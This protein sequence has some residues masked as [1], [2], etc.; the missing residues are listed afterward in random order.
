M[1][2]GI[3]A[4]FYGSIGKGL[5][6]Y[7]EKLIEYLETLDTENEYVIFL[8]KENFDEYVP[9]NRHFEKRLA[10]YS[11]Y[12]FLEQILF[13]IQLLWYRLDIVHFPHFNV[14]F[15]YPKRF[16][17]TIHDLILLHYPTLEN[18]TRSK[19]FYK[20]KFLAYR[21][22]IACAI[23]RAEHIFTVSHFTEKDI[24]TKYPYARGKVS[25]TY[26][27]T[28]PF[29]QFS[30]PQTE[31]KFFEKI[32]LLEDTSMDAQEKN[33]R[34]I[35]K[36]YLLYVGNAYPHKNL[37]AF[38]SLAPQFPM[39]TFVLVGK[40]DYFYARL[41]KLA[42]LQ[43]I[44]NIIF[45]GFV[46]DQ[47]LSSLYRFAVS[48]IFPSFYEGFGLPPLE[49][50]ARGVV[51]LSSCCG[52]LPEILGKAALYF[53]PHTIGSLEEKL[54]EMLHSETVQKEYTR[55]GYIQANKYS[56]ERMAKETLSVY[57]NSIKNKE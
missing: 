43:G 57:R 36:P 45:T 4:R 21:C 54:R 5:G 30:S 32:G 53:D 49:A 18:T 23:Y 22:I 12:G 39:Y 17:V 44:Q 55:R 48:Y 8:L 31:R 11:W 13:P 6:R 9:Q 19:F 40:E 52:S 2:I 33:M 47:K 37:E 3:D 50:M 10:E 25:V 20:M 1:R 41:K 38:L 15:L 29:C 16:V 7:T 27:A 24:L 56:F 26:E 46:D 28:D 14:P 34:D 35:L 51:V 42:E